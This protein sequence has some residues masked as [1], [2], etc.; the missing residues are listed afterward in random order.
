MIWLQIVDHHG[1]D[2]IP[3]NARPQGLY[4]FYTTFL[5]NKLESKTNKLQ[6]LYQISL[7]IGDSFHKK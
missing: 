3:D 1:H 7:N 5:Q 4:Y 2:V 6:T